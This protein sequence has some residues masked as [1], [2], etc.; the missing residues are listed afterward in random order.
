MQSS[1][2]HTGDVIKI[3]Y[4]QN[5]TS[6]DSFWRQRRVVDGDT[7]SIALQS[8]AMYSTNYAPLWHLVANVA[9]E[10]LAK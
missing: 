8:S 10:K 6:S 4:M 5:P 2:L 3:Y 7:H 9:M 1:S